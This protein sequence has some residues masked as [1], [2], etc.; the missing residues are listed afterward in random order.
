VTRS[1]SDTDRTAALDGVLGAE[2]AAWLAGACASAGDRSVVLRAFPA[3]GRRL[4]RGPL[5]GAAGGLHD[6]TVDDAGRARLLRAADPAAL[7]GLLD[8]LYA[9]GDAAERRGVLRSLDL[10]PLGGAGLP[11]V[12]DA[13]RTNDVRLVAAAVGGRYAARHLPDDEFDQAVLKCLFVGVPL[14][15]VA[16]LPAR[17]SARLAR[18]VADFAH[19]RVAAGRDVP[20]DA[21]LVLVRHPAAVDAAGL[22]AEAASTVEAR[23]AAA[24]RFLAGRPDPPGSAGTEE[25]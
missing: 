9:H 22:P 3:M 15:G 13:L 5:P 18:M 23:R 14:D 6:W 2:A 16:G 4:G 10:L 21:W 1:T 17:A 25:G 24:A 11:L 19:E 20:A 7:P 12:R 8:Q